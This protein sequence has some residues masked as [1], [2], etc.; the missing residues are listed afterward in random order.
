VKES[1]QARLRRITANVFTKIEKSKR[2]L[3]GRELTNTISDP[4]SKIVSKTDIELAMTKYAFVH[5]TTLPEEQQDLL[6]GLLA[7]LDQLHFDIIT[8]YY[9][10]G[11]T[12]E[13]IAQ[14]YNK[15]KMWVSRN[16]QESYE[17]M[18][19]V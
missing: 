3:N 1:P 11:K 12:M 16:L 4:D 7:K 6:N 18:R 2:R 15:P 5:V 13:Q 14:V 19:R 8:M 9:H 17:I 10:N